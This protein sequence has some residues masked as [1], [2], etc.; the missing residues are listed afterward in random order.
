[1]TRITIEAPL[2]KVWRGGCETAREE[3]PRLVHEGRRPRCSS[4]YMDGRLPGA[5]KGDGRSFTENA[6][7]AKVMCVSSSP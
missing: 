4:L 1:M 3:L 5:Y 7:I 6:L 2:G